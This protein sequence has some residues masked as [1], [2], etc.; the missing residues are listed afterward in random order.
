MAVEN[1]FVALA[2]ELVD[3]F[4]APTTFD[5]FEPAGPWDPV[6]GNQPKSV[7]SHTLTATSPIDES[8]VMSV[9]GGGAANVA[10]RHGPTT[11][12]IIIDAARMSFDPL[13]KEI[14]VTDTTGVRHHVQRVERI[15]DKT[16]NA[17]W[18]FYLER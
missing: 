4:G 8:M 7:T 5:V 11:E 6:R 18:F 17:A 16:A 12:V 9:V 13:G 15:A 1:E 2:I 14:R 10:L 3:E